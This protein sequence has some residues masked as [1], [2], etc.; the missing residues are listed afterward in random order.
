VCRG[1]PDKLKQV[2][3]NLAI[4]ALEAIPGKG[5]VT[6]RALSAP[7]PGKDPQEGAE[8]MIEDTGAGIA[9]EDLPRIFDPFFTTKPTGTGMGLAIARKI[10]Q[11]HDGTISAE[12]KPG[13]G[14]T[15]RV[16]LPGS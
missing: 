4:N 2:F 9:P 3:L 8:I 5:K 11:G 12:S 1:D 16:W 7:G 13:K 14:T 15:I 6:I 10:V